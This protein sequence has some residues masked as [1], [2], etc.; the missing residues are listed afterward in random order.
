MWKSNVAG[1]GAILCY[2]GAIGWFKSVAKLDRRQVFVRAHEVRADLQDHGSFPFTGV[3]HLVLVEGGID[4][5]G[6]GAEMPIRS[7][8]E[9]EVLSLAVLLTQFED[10]LA[11]RN[12]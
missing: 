12:V 11:S 4:F 1:S 8:Q 7:E 9:Q 5:V 10:G 3:A 6:L 2:P